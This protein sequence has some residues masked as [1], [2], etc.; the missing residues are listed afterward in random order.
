[1][2]G[3]DLP[4]DLRDLVYD[5]THW[6]WTPEHIAGTLL[7]TVGLIPLVGAVKHA[8]ELL[9]PLLRYGDDLLG[10]LKASG[11]SG[12]IL[13][14][15]GALMKNAGLA[16]GSLGFA[17]HGNELGEG[18][19][20]IL[21]H[22]EELAEAA[23]AAIK[24][25]GEAA[26]ALTDAARGAVNTAETAGTLGKSADMLIESAGKTSDVVHGIVPSLNYISP[27]QTNA[28]GVYRFIDP[29]TKLPTPS[30]LGIKGT[31]YPIFRVDQHGINGKAGIEHIN[32]KAPQ[33]QQKFKKT[34]L[35]L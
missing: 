14:A 26:E 12:E 1:M 35:Q 15:A 25:G 23:G 22:G 24:G 11:A 9:G 7:D 32:V 16:A 21:R 6:E 33:G 4:M 34:L 8:D 18:V 13:E 27:L 10:W 29:K 19:E 30:Q 3:L 20:G 31:K 2:T 28:T 17:K 5:L